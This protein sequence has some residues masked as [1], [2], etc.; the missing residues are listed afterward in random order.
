MT[1]WAVDT[2]ARGRTLYTPGERGEEH[3]GVS[4]SGGV[5][6]NEFYRVEFDM[7]TGMVTQIVD[8]DTGQNIVDTQA[9]Y[10]FG[11]VVH[12][13]LGG[14][15]KREAL[16]HDAF[17]NPVG[18]E[19]DVEFVRMGSS[20]H[21]VITASHGG[22]VFGRAVSQSHLPQ[23]DYVTT[24]LWL[25]QGVKR[26]DIQVRINKQPEVDY[27]SLY[28]AFPLALSSPRAFVENAGAVFEVEHEQLPGTCRDF[29]SI[30][31]FIGLQGQEGWALLTPLDSPLVQV[32]DINTARWLE[33]I[34]L[35]RAH[36]YAWLTNNF[37][38]INFPP[39][40]LGQLRFRFVLTTGGTELPQ[41][42]A[43]HFGRAV[44][45]GLVVQSDQHG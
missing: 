23:A 40:Q 9:Q 27:E 11:E 24:E 13:R 29:Y 20:A 38:F 2:V 19:V 36:V 25:W 21:A 34:D 22:P 31:D 5:L 41:Q 43:R 12:E 39:Y 28:V 17:Y 35:Q 33:H 4:C 37:W 44:R 42:Q 30:G 32:N 8:L 7:Q 14:G 3:G 10:A 6:E 45:E 26:L 15:K 16:W 18:D 1:A